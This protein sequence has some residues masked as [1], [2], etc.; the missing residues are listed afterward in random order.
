MVTHPVLNNIGDVIDKIYNLTC[1]KL[2]PGSKKTLVLRGRDAGILHSIDF[3]PI[4]RIAVIFPVEDV[5]NDT[6]E[7]SVFMYQRGPEGQSATKQFIFQPS[8]M[9]NL[10][11][12]GLGAADRRTNNQ[13]ADIVANFIKTG[14]MVAQ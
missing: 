13:V 3:E 8:R 11:I 6:Q 4:Q 7:V 2:P 9:G 10:T 5:A 14:N 12:A 1:N